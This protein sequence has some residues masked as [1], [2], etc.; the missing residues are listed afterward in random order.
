MN[1]L[2]QDLRYGIRLLAKNPGFT[3]V[4][5]LTLALGIGVN[6]AMFSGVKAFIISP[7]AGVEE[8]E[9]LVIPFEVE[10]SGSR[11]DSFSYP[12]YVDYR[13]R[14]S[15]V[16]DGLIANVLVQAVF[17]T[18]E[19][20]DIV[21]GQMVSGN[22]FDVLRV[23]PA[24]GRAF[25]PEED[26]T[27]GSHPVVVLS[28]NLWQ[29]RFS[30]DPAIAGKT[31]FLNGNSFT[32]IGVAPENFQGTKW[33]LGMDFWVPMMMQSQMHPGSDR[34]NSRG[35]HWFE[36]MGRLK[37]GVSREQA[38]S[39]MTAIARQLE[40]AYPEELGNR[41]K[42]IRVAVLPETEGRFDDAATAIT[43]G[44]GMAMAV[45]G[46]ILLIVC[47]NVANL[48]LARGMARRREIGIRLA[49]GARRWR[50]IRQLLTESLVLAII[51]GGLGLM[52][53][54]W[55]SDLMQLFIPVIPYRIAID[56]SPDAS[57]ITFTFIVSV[58]TGIVFGLAPALQS[59]KPDLVPVL[60]G[61]S[62]AMG[63]SRRFSLRNILVVSQVT[64]SF[65]ILAAGGLF[66]KSFQNAKT[67][68]PGFRA[69]NTMAM[70][71]TPGLL[72]YTRDQGQQF[73]RQTVERV[74]ALP[75][76]EAASL[77]NE[78]PLGDSSSSTGPV[79]A[80]G[81]SLSPGEGLSALVNTV[82]PKYFETMRIPLLQGRDFTE[83]DQRETQPVAIINESL[84]RRLWPGENPV[85]K[86]FGIGRDSRADTE[87]IGV[88][89]D[90]KYRSLRESP[91]PFIYYPLTQS[92]NSQMTLLVRTAGEGRSIVSLIR[93][94][95]KA[96]DEKMPLYGVKTMQEHLSYALW[97]QKMGASLALGFGVLAMLIA[98]VGIYS[99]ISY[100]A[101]RRTREIGIR[102]ALGAEAGDVVRMI[103][104]QGLKLA[105]VGVALGLPLALA[106]SQILKSLLFGVS[107]V[108]LFVL[109][110]VSLLLA[111]AGLLAGYFP[112][113]RAARV[114]PGRA[115]RYE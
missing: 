47:A 69:E 8:P 45:V 24:L 41:G 16:F 32:V 74:E 94:E 85:G 25:L 53:S 77:A 90:G 78:L 43:M 31:V 12:D 42:D 1:N 86:R 87:V 73:Y 15:E 35:S 89:R 113:R 4:A 98:S 55:T 9:R 83:L 59:S 60:K 13:D 99:V 103:A 97:G 84:A 36:I 62:G 30:A 18:G 110:G 2:F 100:S 28:H 96:I 54:L 58:A 5:A 70:T 3:A 64:L 71:M 67:A 107:G 7:L 49:L 20:N 81:R 72:G 40:Q 23:R 29:N 102:I 111:S 22:Y 14:S 56:F 6:S 82:S 93:Q 21:W 37:A 50:I 79:I 95:V 51:G 26:R 115:L 91:R 11:S 65:V 108:D 68:D 44:S 34:L 66:I 61:E 101:S 112:A 92:H 17:G 38:A 114:D 105:L 19:G 104:A 109:G 80:E 63:R 39:N 57:V 52:M 75:E 88:A 46:V 33:G 10:A 48:L 27:P 76:V 106:V